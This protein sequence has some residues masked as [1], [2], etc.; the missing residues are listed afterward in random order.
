MQERRCEPRSQVS[1]PV[2]VW[3][4]EGVFAVARAVDAS[5]SGMRLTISPRAAAM[6]HVD[7]MYSL[8]VEAPVPLAFIAEVRHRSGGVGVVLKERLA[9]LVHLTQ[10]AE[11][12]ASAA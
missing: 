12:Q 5:A 9:E 10:P 7:R 1:W 6:I 8:E 3:L 2:R 4:G 11:M